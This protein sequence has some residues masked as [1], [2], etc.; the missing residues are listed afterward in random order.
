ME[1]RGVSN[2]FF[3]ASTFHIT[4][5]FI[6]TVVC[7]IVI[8][9]AVWNTLIGP[10]VTQIRNVSAPPAGFGHAFQG[11]NMTALLSTHTHTPQTHNHFDNQNIICQGG[12]F[13]Q[14]P[15]PLIVK[16]LWNGHICT[17]DFSK[18]R[19]RTPIVKG[20]P[21]WVIFNTQSSY[22]L[23]PTN[24]HSRDICEGG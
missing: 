13:K 9:F 21:Y 2:S 3:Q 8:F 17:A 23:W 20:R 7:F 1:D 14:W 16:W 18:Y 5:L 22:W 15:N 6:F 19:H 24:K 12:V 4:S 10:Q 11:P